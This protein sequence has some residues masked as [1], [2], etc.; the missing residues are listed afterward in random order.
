M[1]VEDQKKSIPK[2][3]RN[4]MP[5]SIDNNQARKIII[6]WFETNPENLHKRAASEARSAFIAAFPCLD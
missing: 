2:E 3:A 5:D 6:K 4:C 1:S